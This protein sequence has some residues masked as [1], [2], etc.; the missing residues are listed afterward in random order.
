[1][2][3]RYRPSL[4]LAL[5]FGLLGGV[6]CSAMTVPGPGVDPHDAGSAL[7][8]G[9]DPV[10]EDAS[11][12]DDAGDPV[13]RDAGE[14]C[15]DFGLV[16]SHRPQAVACAS[17]PAP[18]APLPP[19][20]GGNL[21]GGS[22]DLCLVDGDCS[23]GGTCSCRGSTRAWAGASNG[24]ACISGNC[25]TDSDCGSGGACSPTVSPGCG[26]FYGTEGY[27]CHT[28]A[29]QCLNDSECVNDS[30]VSGYCAY[31]PTVGYWACGYSFCAG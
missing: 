25:R 20:G 19:Y 1:M 31:D 11:K 13:V 6:H 8:G 26:S 3:S 28:C 22:P 10:G 21:D 18:T 9:G 2:V 30:G 24:N 14:R 23:D 12:K 4:G 27:Y 16:K 15:A 7:D 17:T 5:V 29:D